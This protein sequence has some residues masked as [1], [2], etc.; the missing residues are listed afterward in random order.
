METLTKVDINYVN[1]SKLSLDSLC[2]IYASS[3]GI[4]MGY[5]NPVPLRKTLEYHRN[6]GNVKFPENPSDRL[7]NEL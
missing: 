6:L 1:F 4:C 3:F 2:E 7:L 5:T